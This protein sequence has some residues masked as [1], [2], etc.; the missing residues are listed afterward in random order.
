MNV[1]PAFPTPWNGFV[2][3]V[4]FNQSYSSLIG[5]QTLPLHGIQNNGIII[6]GISQ[7]FTGCCLLIACVTIK[8]VC[9]EGYDWAA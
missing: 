6:A 9:L 8:I 7:N 2:E 1:G 3:C 5:C 4:N